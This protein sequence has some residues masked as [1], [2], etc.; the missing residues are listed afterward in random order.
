MGHGVGIEAHENP[1]VS[2]RSEDI[3]SPG[4]VITVEPGIYLEGFGGVRI[5]DMVYIDKKGH[6]I[7]TRS[8]KEL[9]E[10]I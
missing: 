8:T 2:Q 4:S 10:I 1:S 7:L 5:E 9:I 6:N 3:I